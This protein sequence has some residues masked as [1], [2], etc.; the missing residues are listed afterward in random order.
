VR[1]GPARGRAR[2][3]PRFR[4]RL[5]FRPPVGFQHGRN[6]VARFVLVNGMA[7][8]EQCPDRYGDH[9]PG[10]IFRVERAGGK[11]HGSNLLGVTV[12]HIQG[13]LAARIRS[14]FLP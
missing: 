2:A 8:A 9:M 12:S 5:R 13:F 1:L 14:L 3:P 7:A 10:D 6:D 4:R 11:V